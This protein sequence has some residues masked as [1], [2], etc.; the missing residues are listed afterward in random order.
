MTLFNEQEIITLIKLKEEHNKLR[1]KIDFLTDDFMKNDLFLS[2]NKSINALIE[3]DK[4]DNYDDIFKY[5]QNIMSK[6]K[7]KA[8]VIS[9]AAF[10][11]LFM[12]FGSFIISLIISAIIGFF[13]AF[14]SKKASDD[15]DKFIL[16]QKKE[17]TIRELYDCKNEMHKNCDNVSNIIRD[18][19]LDFIKNQSIISLNSL[20][21]QGFDIIH[22]E[23]LEGILSKNLTKQNY[24]IIEM[25]DPKEPD[26][27]ITVY[28][29]KIA[30]NITTTHLQI[31]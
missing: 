20:K 25:A 26:Q 2:K 28:K 27:K 12:I 31:D 11:I 8:W 16:I 6:H 1:S 18:R 5:Y 24:D 23:L 17:N 14:G 29:S 4:F 19:I 10:F 9:G 22:D 3:I 15:S 21:E 30:K 7:K 13:S